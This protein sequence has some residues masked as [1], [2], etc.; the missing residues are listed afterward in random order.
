M[1][2]DSGLEKKK[3]W[4]FIDFVINNDYDSDAICYDI[5]DENDLSGFNNYS[6][7]NIFKKLK[8]KFLLKKIKNL[9]AMKPNDNDYLPPFKF[10]EAAFY[11]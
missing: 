11:H 10:G 6:Q 7:C 2:I 8:S 4:L 5:F 9:Y 3:A 1:L